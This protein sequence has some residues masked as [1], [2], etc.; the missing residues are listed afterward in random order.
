MR[1]YRCFLPQFGTLGYPK[2]VLL[3]DHRHT[4]VLKL[5]LLFNYGMRAYKDL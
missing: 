2:P 3:V 5:N 1:R 4:E